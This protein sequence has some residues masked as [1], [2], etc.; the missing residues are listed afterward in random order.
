MCLPLHHHPTVGNEIINS[1]RRLIE[2]SVLG[3][4]VVRFLLRMRQRRQPRA[5]LFHLTSHVAKPAIS[6]LLLSNQPHIS[7]WLLWGWLLHL[8]AGS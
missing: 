5:N 1:K 4:V 8:Y 2:K 7:I 3:L 6:L